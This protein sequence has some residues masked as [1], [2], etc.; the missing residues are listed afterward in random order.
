MNANST[1]S[2][3]RTHRH[4][5]WLEQRLQ[6]SPGDDVGDGR[7][8]DSFRI[9]SRPST[10]L[11]GLRRSNR[12]RARYYAE[13]TPEGRLDLERPEASDSDG[14]MDDALSEYAASCYLP[15]TRA[16]SS[17]NVRPSTLKKLNLLFDVYE[18]R[19]KENSSQVEE[20]SKRERSLTERASTEV[21]RQIAATETTPKQSTKPQKCPVSS[22]AEETTPSGD[23][24]RSPNRSSTVGLWCLRQLM[25]AL[26]VL[27]EITL[28]LSIK[29]FEWLQENLQ[30][31][32]LCLWNQFMAPL[33]Y[34]LPAR[35]QDFNAKTVVLLIVVAPFA[36]L[37]A[38]AYGTVCG[39]YW[40]NRVL[41]METQ[42][43]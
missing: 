20:G 14:D 4:S 7:K 29:V 21:P 33:L 35:V 10:A 36:A 15:R 26:L 9:K 22:A 24:P 17:L 40:F 34:P 12:G 6:L 5:R 39:L 28:K 1:P 16:S 30:A 8:E 43:A 31:I 2:D 41:L 11:D 32:L 38:L 19:V 3:T 42:Q 23:S 13:R 37:L 25:L 18:K 27:S